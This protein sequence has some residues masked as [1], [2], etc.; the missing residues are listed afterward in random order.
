MTEISPETRRA[1]EAV[2]DGAPDDYVLQPES[3]ADRLPPEAAPLARVLRQ[4]KAA[5]AIQRY[6]GADKKALAAQ[7]LYRRLGALAVYGLAA[8]AVFGA[9]LILKDLAP[10]DL[11]NA[12]VDGLQRTVLA[13]QFVAVL[14]TIVCGLWLSFGRPFDRWMKARGDA[15]QARQELF[16]EV[17]SAQ[18]SSRPG[19][20][21]Y[22]PL[23]LEYVRRYQLG[24]Q[25]AYYKIRSEEARR[26][27][28][29]M[30]GAQL[31]T[32]PLLAIAGIPLA[33]SFYTTA[34]GEVFL[35]FSKET[36]LVLIA[37]GAVGGG[38]ASIFS[39]LSLLHL[40]RRNASKFAVTYD[41]LSYLADAPLREAQA[42]AAAG[43]RARVFWFVNKLHVVISSEH[44][45]WVQ[46]WT[47]RQR[48]EEEILS[49][50]EQ[51]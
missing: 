36:E 18:E 26:R 35:E 41:N 6:S 19:E 44:R 32:W 49:I 28:R 11:L 43:R 33:S 39:S 23:A 17:I 30:R 12:H 37:L 16:E 15:E 45:E 40:D 24:V 50:S 20:S 13:L 5:T 2:G 25:L 10:G 29:F 27:S 22:L 51:T 42:D 34:T 1:A 9:M 3:H 38:L 47:H 46:I 21:P 8:P 48:L 7:K 31:M 14:V 4:E